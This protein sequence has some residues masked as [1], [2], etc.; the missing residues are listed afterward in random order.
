MKVL[1]LNPILYTA[2]NNHIPKV[3]SIKDCMIYNLAIGFSSL[4]HDV[5]LIAASEYKPTAKEEY[6]INVIFFKSFIRRIFLPSVLPFQLEIIPFL[7]SKAS[8]FD[9]IISSEVFSFTTL[10]S[11][12]ISPKKLLVWH[13]LAIHTKKFRSIPSYIWYNIVSKMFLRK[14]QVVARSESSK[15]FLGK[16]FANVKS[17]VIEHGIN[18]TKFAFSR[19]KKKQFII[20]A[21]LIPRKNIESIISFFSDFIVDPKYMDYTLLIV[22][23]GPL[24]EHLRHHIEDRGLSKVIIFKGFTAHLELNQLIAESQALLINT[25]KDNNM[26]SIPESIVSGTPVISNTIPTN[27][28]MINKF[29]LGIAKMSWGKAE[30]IEIVENNTYYVEKCIA[31][32]DRLSTQ[33][34]ANNLINT[35]TK[36]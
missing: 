35:F 23:R 32:R 8:S 21:Q 33:T 15:I 10:F 19:S 20:V 17:N 18:L 36:D 7:F 28:E 27:S 1:I 6:E 13:E 3:S 34:T 26:V 16:Y 12:I 22:G 9:I 2:D 24:E 31:F 25:L 11:A 29:Q 4:G 14:I 5:T 30:L